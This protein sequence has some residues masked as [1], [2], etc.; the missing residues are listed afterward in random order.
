MVCS[1]PKIKIYFDD[2]YEK[3]HPDWRPS[4]IVRPQH[5]YGFSIEKLKQLPK[6]IFIERAFCLQ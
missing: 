4:L 1:P 3:G 6:I 5:K 2:M